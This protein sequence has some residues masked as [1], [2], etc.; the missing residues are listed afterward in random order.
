M[1]PRGGAEQLGGRSSWQRDHEEVGTDWRKPE[2]VGKQ[3]QGH[4]SW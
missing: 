1:G 2:H 3:Q 4:K